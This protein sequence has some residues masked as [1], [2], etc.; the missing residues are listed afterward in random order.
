MLSKNVIFNLE[1][2]SSVPVCVCFMYRV[3]IHSSI[4]SHLAIV[5]KAA[6]N[7]AAHIFELMFSYSL[8][9]HPGEDLLDH[10]VVLFLIF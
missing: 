4:D 7:I 1:W 8:D 6:V 3:F 10:M 2:L 5:N 9:K